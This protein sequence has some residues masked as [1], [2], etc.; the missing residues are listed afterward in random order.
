MTSQIHK[1]CLCINLGMCIR[2]LLMCLQHLTVSRHTSWP[3]C[4]LSHW[5]PALQR[6]SLAA[7]AARP[8]IG[9]R[10][11]MLGNYMTFPSPKASISYWLELVDEYPSPSSAR[12]LW[13][14]CEFPKDMSPMAH[15]FHLLHNTLSLASYLSCLRYLLYLEVHGPLPHHLLY[16]NL[17]INICFWR[18][19]NPNHI[20]GLED[21]N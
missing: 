15:S 9:S 3:T 11:R 7:R 4:W 20:G 19:A 17:C 1:L 10:A 16:W 21:V 2:Q 12:A 13:T 14:V 6:F 18:N 5:Q 8:C